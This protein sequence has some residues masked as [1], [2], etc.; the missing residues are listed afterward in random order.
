[1]CG[2]IC[3]TKGAYLLAQRLSQ[4]TV[5]FDIESMGSATCISFTV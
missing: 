1:M 5:Y 3:L 2:K 4:V